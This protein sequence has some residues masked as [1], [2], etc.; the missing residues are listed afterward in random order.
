MSTNKKPIKEGVFDAAD[1]FVANF[2]DG[3]TKGAANVI[4]KKAENAKLPPEAIA[5]MK[6]MEKDAERFKKMLKD[7]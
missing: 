3:L 7:L 5:H 1:K 4:I 2:F 6:Q